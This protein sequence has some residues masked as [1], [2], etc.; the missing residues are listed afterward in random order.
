MRVQILWALINGEMSV[1]NIANTID[2]SLQNTSQHLRIMKDK[3]MVVSRRDG[4]IIYYR[5]AE[6]DLLN[7]FQAIL[8]THQIKMMQE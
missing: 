5:V 6:N 7:N 8:Q 4:Q 2:A 3:C 1:G